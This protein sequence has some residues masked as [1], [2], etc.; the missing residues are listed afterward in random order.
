MVCLYVTSVEEGAGKT[1]VCAGLGRYLL[2]KGKKVGFFKP[3]IT[4]GEQPATEATDRDALFMKQILGLDEPVGTICPVIGGQGKL[5]GKIKEAYSMV[6]SGKDVVIAEGACE[7]SMVKALAARVIAV[8]GYSD[9]LAGVKFTDRYKDFEEQMLGVVLNK[10][11][12]R[13]L[14]RVRNEVTQLPGT[15]IGIL[16][17]LA[18]DRVL[19]TPTIGGLAECV[20]G[21]IL[22]SREQLAELV[23]NFMLGAMT[24]DPGPDY[25]GRKTNKAV[26]L[27]SDRPDM[28]LAAFETATKC[29]IL[30]G[31]TP[32]TPT[33]LYWAE[34]KKIPIIV[35]KAD[36]TATVDSIENA[37]GKGRFNQEKKL[38]RLAEV[39]EQHF[40]FPGVLKGLSLAG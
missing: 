13:R 37:L 30:C 18:E 4:S 15:G 34:T 14:E 33:V 1:A 17:V 24:A 38:P 8:E 28:Q 29:L 25:F 32:P 21:E 5:A 35:T 19:F 26:V 12:G 11:P 39:M 10:V 20:E 36:V 23:E 6:S 3:V 9:Q 7:P 27:R 2:G 40:D 31:D 16:G 22:N